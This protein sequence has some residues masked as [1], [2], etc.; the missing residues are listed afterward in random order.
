MIFGIVAAVDDGQAK[1]EINLHCAG[2]TRIRRPAKPLGPV[3]QPG[4]LPKGQH[5]AC[6]T[7]V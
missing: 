4:S 3:V 5:H 6:N 2:M 1:G 7:M